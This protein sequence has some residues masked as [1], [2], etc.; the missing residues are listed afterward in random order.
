MAEAFKIWRNP[1]N[2]DELITFM[3]DFYPPDGRPVLVPQ[4]LIELG[5]APGEYT[6]K[7]PDSA[8]HSGMIAKWQKLRV[9]R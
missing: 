5:F 9:P 8:R 6:V 1:S 7:V 2:A 4:D 3:G